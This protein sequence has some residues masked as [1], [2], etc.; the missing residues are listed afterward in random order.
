M[1]RGEMRARYTLQWERGGNTARYAVLTA[2][3][4]RRSIPPHYAMFRSHTEHDEDSS[5]S[6][7][8]DRPLVIPMMEEM[9]TRT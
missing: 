8:L 6:S 2:T 4:T 1:K 9:H 7:G 5:K 3:I